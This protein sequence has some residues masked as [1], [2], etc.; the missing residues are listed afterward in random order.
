MKLEAASVPVPLAVPV[1][2]TEARSRLASKA[3][4]FFDVSRTLGSRRMQDTN[5]I[6]N[7]K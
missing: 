7:N 2:V 1:P 6:D 5:K 4:G 3:P